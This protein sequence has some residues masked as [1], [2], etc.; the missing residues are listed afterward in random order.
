MVQKELIKLL[1]VMLKEE[2]RG[3]ELLLW[4]RMAVEIGMVVGV[5]P[6]GTPHAV[7]QRMYG[8]AN[9]LR[10][11]SFHPNDLKGIAWIV[12]EDKLGPDFKDEPCGMYAA[13]ECLQHSRRLNTC[14]L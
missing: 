1:A 13:L 11:L 10:M 7:T 6:S 9:M 4:V 5:T 14:R 8:T 3:E 2:D 12:S